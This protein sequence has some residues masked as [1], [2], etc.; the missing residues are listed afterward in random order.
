[1][2]RNG[3]FADDG[4]VLDFARWV[5]NALTG[6]STRMDGID[7]SISTTNNNLSNLSS[8]VDTRFTAA[9]TY[10]DTKSAG[11]L[12]DAK[13]Y[14]GT[15]T[16][17]KQDK[18]TLDADVTALGTDA[19]KGLYG[20]L[21]A[22]RKPVDRPHLF[23]WKSA[24]NSMPNGPASIVV[25][26]DSMA[27]RG[28]AD[29]G[30]GWAERLAYLLG[31][32][33]ITDIANG[34]GPT[35]S[36]SK[37]WQANIGGATSANYLVASTLTKIG[38]VKPNLVLHT[39]GSNDVAHGVQISTFKSNLRARLREVFNVHNNCN[40]VLIHTVARKDIP[41]PTYPWWQYGQAMADVA[42]EAE[43]RDLVSYLDVDAE[44][45]LRGTPSPDAQQ[46]Y[47]SDNIH[48]NNRGNRAVSEIIIR[49]LGVMPPVNET[50]MLT[51][52][53]TAA[54]NNTTGYDMATINV[55]AAPFPRY[56]LANVSV[57][58]T[59]LS[60]ENADIV[61]ECTPGDFFSTRIIPIADTGF[62]QH[63]IAGFKIPP[64][65]SMTVKAAM[66]CYPATV[67]VNGSVSLSQFTLAL[68]AE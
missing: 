33:G 48:L 67:S 18:A 37:V 1:M 30:Y 14:A 29:V 57:F 15:L 54:T 22:Y 41:S 32:G 27:N 26:G 58:M 38:T 43:F 19:T 7:T 34:T 24:L 63:G 60:G 8:S 49:Y 59:L 64:N 52:N 12:T 46:F 39:I 66:S 44:M 17:T 10:T 16:G 45:K 40:Q 61:V 2:P 3:M 25:L 9:T 68:T 23:L 42:A 6:N 4:L 13:A 5:R 36:G 35:T 51:S 55:P 21:D 28:L 65:T 53:I 62:T 20:L 11:A 56:A 47:S 31:P 50:E